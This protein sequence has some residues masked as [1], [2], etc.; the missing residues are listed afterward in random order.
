MIP[1]RMA[2]LRMREHGQALAIEDQPGD[3]LRELLGLDRKLAAAARMWADRAVVHAAD[4]DSECFAG[5]LHEL[6]RLRA[7]CG[8]V[9]DVGVILPDRA[10]RHHSAA[11]RAAWSK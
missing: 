1:E 10:H 9:I 11:V 2:G 3:H 7:R 4:L 6:F 8:V 5:R